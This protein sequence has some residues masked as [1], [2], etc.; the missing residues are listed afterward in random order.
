MKLIVLSF[1]SILLFAGFS[2]C[3]GNISESINNLAKSIESVGHSIERSV[4]LTHDPV[5]QAISVI[6]DGENDIN[7]GSADWQTVLQRVAKDLPEG[8]SQD[9]RVDAQNIADRSVA[10]TGIEFR[11]NVDF[12]NRRAI[13]NLEYLKAELLGK[14]PRALPPALDH[15]IPI[16][17]DLNDQPSKWSTISYIGYDLDHLDSH[18]RLFGVYAVDD[19]GNIYKFP[20]DRIGRTT[21]YEVTLNVGGLAKWLS[22]KKIRKIFYNWNG[23]EDPQGEIVINPWI[24]KIDNSPVIRSSESTFVPPYIF[25]DAGLGFFIPTDDF[26]LEDEPMTVN[27]T[28]RVYRTNTEILTYLSMTAYQSP[29]VRPPF[30]IPSYPYVT[31]IQSGSLYTAPR[32]WEII[33]VQ[34]SVP[35]E[36]VLYQQITTKGINEYSLPAGEVVNKFTV[37]GDKVEDGPE[38]GSW[39]RVIAHWNEFHVT[40]REMYPQWMLS[41]PDSFD[42]G[43]YPVYVEA[44]YNLNSTNGLIDNLTF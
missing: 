9:I 7:T 35:S 14:K 22:D 19:N 29:Y 21:H 5:Q 28:A 13:E 10:R 44:L 42:N 20:E 26:K 15:V 38:A 24:P 27:I 41:F 2:G 40:L 36:S 16:S 31:G 34:P 39:T 12:L 3:A 4:E 43:D 18:G 33:D 8:I 23:S 30:P 11:A 6:D 17:I 32:G 25:T 37:W 1:L